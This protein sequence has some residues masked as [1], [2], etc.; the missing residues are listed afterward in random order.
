MRGRF[1]KF[2][3]VAAFGAM[4]AGSGAGVRAADLTVSFVELTR[5]LETIAGNAK[6]Y[7]NNVP[8]GVFASQSYLQITSTQQYAIPIPVRSFNLLGSTYAY[9]VS[10]VS[11]ANVRL[12]PVKSALRL[13]VAF[14]SDA[15]E[16]IVSCISG[17]CGLKDVLPDI[18]W[19]NARVNIDFI[20]I[21]LGGSLSLEV[22]AVSTEGNPRAVCKQTADFI[23]RQ[24]C[25]LGLPFANRTI[26]QL[27]ASLPAV[28]RDAINQPGIQTQLADGLKRYLTIGQ[29]GE[30]AI[31]RV[32]VDPRTLTVTFR[33]NTASATPN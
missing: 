23:E 3:V 10:D 8:G 29:A 6:V 13:T 1:L 27:R 4:F 31:N 9:F 7:L 30:V 32:S 28:L 25:N 18:Q 16:A 11:S 21:Q 12:A 22:K 14:E 15:P 26:K 24:A 20:P 33:F 2:G 5:L 17:G 19:D